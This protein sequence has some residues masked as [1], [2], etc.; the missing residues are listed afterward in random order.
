MSAW[1]RTVA[2]TPCESPAEWAV[3][4]AVAVHCG[5]ADGLAW[6]SVRRL[7][8][9]T[10]LSEKMGYSLSRP[11][12][13]PWRDHRIRA[14]RAP[15]AHAQDQDARLLHIRQIGLSVKVRRNAR[16]HECGA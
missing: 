15:S 2:E 1:M 8:A 14:A 16:A 9:M 11:V 4:M 10:G 7:A 13:G 12:G 5:S 6:P 3:L